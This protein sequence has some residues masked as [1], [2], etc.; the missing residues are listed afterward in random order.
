ME[1]EDDGPG[2]DASAIHDGIGLSNTRERLKAVYGPAHAFDVASGPS[3]GAC[4][5]IVIPFQTA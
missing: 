5:R 4:V 2:I 1:V 3:G